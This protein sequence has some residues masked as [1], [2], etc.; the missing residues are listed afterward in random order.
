M[1]AE[2]ATK[3]GNTYL[4]TPGAHLSSDPR[5][6]MSYK[7]RSCGGRGGVIAILLQIERGKGN[8]HLVANRKPIMNHVQYFGKLNCMLSQSWQNCILFKLSS[9]PMLRIFKLRTMCSLTRLSLSKCYLNNRSKVSVLTR[10]YFILFL[11]MFS[12]LNIFLKIYLG[13]L[14]LGSH[15]AKAQ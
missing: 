12:R 9:H 4:F 11:S 14:E 10:V 2:W 8:C 6:Y 1:L 3:I 15:L 5:Q 13:S 7:V